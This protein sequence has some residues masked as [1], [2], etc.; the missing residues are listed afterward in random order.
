[1]HRIQPENPCV[2]SRLG[3]VDI[4]YVYDI[5]LAQNNTTINMN[6]VNSMFDTTKYTFVLDYRRENF[7][8]LGSLE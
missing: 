6:S 1:M 2:I 4:V 3:G 7:F 5:V 8:P